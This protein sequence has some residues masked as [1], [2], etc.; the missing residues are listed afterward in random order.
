MTTAS[1]LPEPGAVTDETAAALI[2]EV[3]NLAGAVRRT[4]AVNRVLGAV[5]VLV[6][7]LAVTDAFLLR[8]QA[9]AN[10]RIERSLAQ[11]YVTAQQQVQTR[12]QV[13]CPLYGALVA[14][15]SDPTRTAGL[16]P[17]QKLRANNAIQVLRNGYTTLG[18]QPSLTAAVRPAV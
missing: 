17:A 6:L 10:Q 9:V 13:L 12:T 11:N 3:G 5:L 1:G 18:C 2:A 14:I 7:A 4:R 8:A 15:A 16:T